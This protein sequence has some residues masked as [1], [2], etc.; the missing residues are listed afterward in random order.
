MHDIGCLLLGL[1]LR[2]VLNRIFFLCC[3]LGCEAEVII[4]R[5]R[6]LMSLSRLG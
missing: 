3:T 1:V 5:P 4:R 6:D 2:T